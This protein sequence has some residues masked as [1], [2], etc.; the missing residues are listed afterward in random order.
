MRED[1]IEV[2]AKAL[3]ELE[4]LKYDIENVYNNSRA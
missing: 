3:E 1:I 4:D 2:Q